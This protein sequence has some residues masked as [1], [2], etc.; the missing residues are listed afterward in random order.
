MLMMGH[1][2][3][4]CPSV[5]RYNATIPASLTSFRPYGPTPLPTCL[6]ADVVRALLV[7]GARPGAVGEKGWTSLMAA[8]A[9]GHGKIVRELLLLAT[10]E[11]KGEGEGNGGGGGT[12]VIDARNDKGCTALIMASRNGFAGSAR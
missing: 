3:H 10:Q 8:A 9:E 12:A 7:A 5:S 4:A 6:D 2:L 1:K 11:E